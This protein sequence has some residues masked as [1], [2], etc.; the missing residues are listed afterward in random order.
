MGREG[1][2]LGG[3]TLY[4]PRLRSRRLRRG[5]LL[6]HLKAGGIGVVEKG[7]ETEGEVGSLGRI[8]SILII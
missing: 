7:G 8:A 1:C 3:G 4:R 6:V 2:R 5:K